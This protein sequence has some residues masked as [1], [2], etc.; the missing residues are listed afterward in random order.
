MKALR[1]F[2]LLFFYFS[3]FLVRAQKPDMDSLLRV[4]NAEPDTMRVRTYGFISFAYLRKK[5]DSALYYGKEQLA[6]AKKL[7]LKREMMNGNN[8][9]ALALKYLNNYEEALK[10]QTEALKLAREIKDPKSEGAFLAAIAILYK[11]MMDYEKSEE[12]FLQAIEK[13]KEIPYSLAND[14]L[15]YAGLLDDM[16]RFEDAWAY[17][18]KAEKIYKELN[19]PDR[20]NIVLQNYAAT[21]LNQNKMEEAIAKNTEALAIAKEFGDEVGQLDIIINLGIAR[22][23]QEKFLLAVEY[24]KQALELA[25]EIPVPEN[26]FYQLHNLARAYGGAKQ[27]EQAFR[28]QRES[29]FIQDS[30]FYDEKAQAQA[31]MQA[32]FETAEKDLEISQLKEAKAR[33]ELENTRLWGG[34]GVA[35]LLLLT[36]GLGFLLYRQRQER[37]LE[38]EL[39]MAQKEQF[40][41]VLSA[42]ERERSRIAGE[43]HDSLGQML[44][45][46]KLQLSSLNPEVLGEE[47]KQLQNAIGL[48]DE[49]VK[50]VRQISH[51]LAPPALMRGGL[52]SALRDLARLVRSTD[53]LEF[54]LTIEATESSIS[55]ANEVHLYRIIQ[56]LINNSIK[57]AG[58]SKMG[59]HLTEESDQLKL[60][61]WD[62]GGGFDLEKVLESEGGL[63]WQS[64]LGRMKLLDGI[65][66]V[67]SDL[68][69]GTK[70]SLQIPIGA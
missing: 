2:F 36:A 46:T 14:Y 60:T 25:K 66:D 11:R 48:I 24:Y 59:L 34:L 21:L 15:N 1:I 4:V 54:D 22:E 26:I 9:S 19:R 44:S 55:K 40:R 7:G 67:E 43:L 30:L 50:E 32:K 56:E 62:N 20:L 47:E 23:K 69:E 38:V 16:K 70:I 45:T 39:K 41:A 28:Y 8:H 53:Q 58:C 63:G 10:H 49:S 17:Y 37:R 68:H 31:E 35:G 29:V 12:L 27:F 5:P 52:I 3:I 33:E 65:V 61:I 42:E 57:H 64:I 18:E 13:H 51:N 6:L